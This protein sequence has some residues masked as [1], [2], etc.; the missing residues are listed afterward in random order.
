MQIELA[1]VDHT[2][3]LEA[4]VLVSFTGMTKNIDVSA[5]QRSARGI[6]DPGHHFESQVAG[7]KP[8]ANVAA[9]ERQ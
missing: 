5:A 6:R 7:S 1:S 3:E 4:T 9:T 2:V 8:A